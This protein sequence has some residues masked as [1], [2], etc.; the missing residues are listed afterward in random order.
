L[1]LY[2]R[3]EKKLKFN[4]KEKRAKI[5]GSWLGS[6]VWEG[7]RLQW[8]GV[9]GRGADVVFKQVTALTGIELSVFPCVSVLVSPWVGEVCLLTQIG[10]TFLGGMHRLG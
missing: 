1:S 10:L 3:F 9:T 4:L 5:T 6:V 2:Q 8:E 7:Q